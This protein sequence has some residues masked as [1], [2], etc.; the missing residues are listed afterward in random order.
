MNEQNRIRSRIMEQTESC[1]WGLKEGEGISQR[2]YTKDPWTWTS[3]W[4]LITGVR[5]QDTWRRAKGE[6]V[7]QP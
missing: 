7:G 1:K 4:G 6:K 2:T 5:E 3:M